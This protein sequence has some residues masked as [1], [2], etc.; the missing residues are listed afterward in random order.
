MEGEEETVETVETPETPVAPAE[1]TGGGDAAPVGKDAFDFEEPSDE[2][3]PEETQAGEQEVPAEGEAAE[4]EEQSD[5]FTPELLDRARKL[6]YTENEAR[7]EFEDPAK[8]DRVLTRME[9]TRVPAQAEQAKPAEAAKTPTQEEFKITLPADAEP[10][11][12]KQFEALHAHHENRYKALE[13]KL[14][15]VLQHTQT[16]QMQAIET[17]V[18]AL[19]SGM[20]EE[21][22]TLFGEGAGRTLSGATRQ[23]RDKVLME[24]DALHTGYLKTGQQMPSEAELHRRAVQNLFG[25]DIKKATQQGIAKTLQKRKTQHL[26]RPVAKNVKTNLKPEQSATKNLAEKMRG[27]GIA[28]EVSDPDEDDGF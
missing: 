10:E 9:S 12:R 25:T 11:V 18:D 24:M 26:A 14:D 21:G 27:M 16:Q 15:G 6:G 13:Q 5:G 22:K 19:F 7:A 20:G 3:I 4:E 8:L 1:G 28:V 17:R 23:N 2:P